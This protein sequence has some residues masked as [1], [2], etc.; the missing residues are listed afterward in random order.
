MS[1]D[2]DHITCDYC[3]SDTAEVFNLHDDGYH[4]TAWCKGCATTIKDVGGWISRE[5]YDMIRVMRA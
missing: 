3:A 4:I 1:N 2:P 5:E